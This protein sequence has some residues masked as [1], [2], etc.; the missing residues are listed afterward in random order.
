MQ[1]NLPVLAF[2]RDGCTTTS[3]MIAPPAAVSPKGN[4]HWP[5]VVLF[6]KIFPELT[7]FTSFVVLGM[8]VLPMQELNAHSKNSLPDHNNR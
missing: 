4:L 1:N 3:I 6:S 7:S 2:A 8:I 5:M